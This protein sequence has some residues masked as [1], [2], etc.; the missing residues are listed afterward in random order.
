MALLCA[1]VLMVLFCVLKLSVVIEVPGEDAYYL[2]P[3]LFGKVIYLL[4]ELMLV[5]LSTL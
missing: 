3:R 5:F 2:Q 4:N 1:C